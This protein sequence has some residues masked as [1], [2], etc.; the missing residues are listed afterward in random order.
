MFLRAG[1]RASWPLLS[2]PLKSCCPLPG[3]LSVQ[4]CDWINTPPTGLLG[5]ELGAGEGEARYQAKKKPL[6]VY[7]SL[8]QQEGN[9]PSSKTSDFSAW[10]NLDLILLF[11][12]CRW[13]AG[14]AMIKVPV[15]IRSRPHHG[16][17]AGASV[18]VCQGQLPGPAAC[19]AT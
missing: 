1:A 9:Q 15:E 7:S 8:W 3:C 13:E 5:P 17:D 19:I 14:S 4:P 10:A 11:T 2:C 18:S 6:S 12:S 16:S